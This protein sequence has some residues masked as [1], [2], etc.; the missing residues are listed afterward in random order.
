MGL[1]VGFL[2]DKASKTFALLQLVILILSWHKTLLDEIIPQSSSIL[3]CKEG[4][5]QPKA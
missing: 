4:L 2:A 3:F 5:I 1:K